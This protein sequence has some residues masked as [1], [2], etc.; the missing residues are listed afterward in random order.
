MDGDTAQG[1]IYWRS[2]RGLLELELLLIPFA[3]ERFEDLPE[4]EQASYVWLLEHDDL[5]IYDWI[6]GRST[7]E[8][9]S[10]HLILARIR[11]HNSSGG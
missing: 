10:L 8:D 2:R 11:E 1:R 5:D 4:E 9:E 6:Q 3:R 7:P